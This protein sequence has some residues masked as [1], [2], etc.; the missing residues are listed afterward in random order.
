MY[1]I[2]DFAHRISKEM[3]LDYQHV[4]NTLSLLSDGATIPFVAR[5]RKEK[6]GS[7]DEEV[8]A[9]LQKRMQQLQAL[10]KRKEAILSALEEQEKLT[11]EL[12]MLV[13]NAITMQE[14]EDIYLPY[15]PK[16]RTRAM[17]AR[18][19]GL[20]PLAS[21]I[22]VQG[23]IDVEKTALTFVIAEK[24]V[25][26][27]AEALAGARD[28]IAEFI[29]EDRQV[30]DRIRKLFHRSAVITSKVVSGKEEEGKT[31]RLYFEWNESLAKAPSHRVLA[32][33][34]G[35]NEG[36]LKVNLKVEPEESLSIIERLHL[37]G[38][39]K[40]SMQVK[41]AIADAWKRLLEPS[42][43]NEIRSVY[44]EKADAVAIRVFVENLRQLL[45]APP[46]GP[47]RVLAID[48]GFRTGCKL[49][50]LDQH[51]QLMHNDTIYP[52]P[53]NHEVKQAIQ[54][55]K[56]L[57]NAYKIE[58]IAVGNGTAGRE[59]ED[60][61]KSIRFESDVMALMVNESGASVY[62]ASK[63]ARDE[64]PDYDITVRG[65]VS[66]GRRLTDPLAELVK[67][68]PKSIGVGQYQH[69][70]DQKALHESLVQTVESCVNAVGVELNTA[71]EQLLSYVSGV[72]PQMA[73]NI[74]RYRKEAGG[75]RDRRELLKVN[76]LGDKAYEQC[77]GFLRIRGGDYPLDASAVHPESYSVVEK[78]AE[79]I[80]QDVSD[81]IGRKNL[82]NEI[83]LA[84][85]LSEKIGKETLNDILNELEKPG[86][87]PRQK[88]EMFVFS[89]DIRTINDL[90]VG[91]VLN[92]IVTNITAFGAFVDVGVHQDGLVHLS[93]L[94][95]RYVR[96]PNEVVKINQKVRVEVLQV[97]LERN[98]INLTMKVKE[99]KP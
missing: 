57:V 65:A 66:I 15:K 74:I 63:V 42:M 53:P 69:D 16:R 27:V 38:N 94:A 11:P 14:L 89:K 3:N 78:I 17:I 60:F 48:P 51:G 91:M 72:G 30:R 23:N 68:D 95:N 24:G 26:S 98:R 44:K 56:N 59:T 83:D 39:N 84:S 88:F 4:R 46:L 85:F 77:A 37:K 31:Y 62:S 67:I 82:K 10:D 61:I 29:A 19:K 2:A 79:S 81:L 13:V 58:V 1:E 76:R 18:E 20:E 70:V 32:L 75:F 55:I 9:A 35:E 47:K 50:V 87:D 6:T 97:D 54:K 90:Q 5:Y 40:A 28:I 22:L 45:L 49:V 64:F 36:F 34:R 41:M 43:E 86:H 80:G 12:K 99:D 21:L 92:G 96:D 25:A 33:F 73:A 52:H 93:Q 8:I 71:S 7:M